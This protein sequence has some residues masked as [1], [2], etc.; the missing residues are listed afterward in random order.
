M[1][2]RACCI[3]TTFRWFASLI[4]SASLALFDARSIRVRRALAMT[5]ALEQR[6]TP[7]GSAMI[8]AVTSCAETIFAQK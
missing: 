2:R 4:R 7:D 8:I 3:K 6:L 1:I 5:T